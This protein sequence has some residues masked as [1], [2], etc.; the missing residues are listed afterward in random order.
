M[1]FL[2]NENTAS[3]MDIILLRTLYIPKLNV[4]KLASKT[5]KTT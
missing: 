5:T 1:C 3:C 4:G 2:L